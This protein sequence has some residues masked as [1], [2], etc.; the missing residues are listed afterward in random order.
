M[1]S[2]KD[3]KIVKH[4]LTTP[5]MITAFQKVYSGVTISLPNKNPG[6]FQSMSASSSW[7]S[8]LLIPKS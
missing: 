6:T 3:N 2:L 4:F 5:M 1:T 8:Q 7:Q